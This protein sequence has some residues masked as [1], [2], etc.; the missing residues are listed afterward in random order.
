LVGVS[1][2]SRDMRAVSVVGLY[3]CGI[4]AGVAISRFIVWRRRS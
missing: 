2:F 3:A 1:I 4:I